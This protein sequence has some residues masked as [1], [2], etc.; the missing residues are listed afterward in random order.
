MK[1]ET[2]GYGGWAPM[3]FFDGKAPDGSMKGTEGFRNVV[4]GQ[5]VRPEKGWNDSPPYPTGD[6]ASTRHA[7]DKYREGWERIWGSANQASEN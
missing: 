2:S 5:E 1:V 3:K 6:L 4:N 7:S